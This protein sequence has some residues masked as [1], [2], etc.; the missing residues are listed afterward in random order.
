MKKYTFDIVYIKNMCFT[1][2]IETKSFPSDNKA[3]EH[4]FDLCTK[5]KVNE[6]YPDSYYLCKW[7]IKEDIP[8]ISTALNRALNAGI[9]IFA[10]ASNTGANYPITFPARPHGIFVL[11]QQMAWAPHP[12]L[13]HLLKVRKNIALLAKRC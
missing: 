4:F 2:H 8:S 13:I 10:S 12:P 5:F 7:G 6:N 1:H 11:A 3:R 9:L